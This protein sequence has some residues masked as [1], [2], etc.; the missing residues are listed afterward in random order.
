VLEACGV[1]DEGAAASLG[2]AEDAPGNEAAGA[3]AAVDANVA[4]ADAGAP[5]A[6]DAGAPAA[7]DAGATEEVLAASGD[8]RRAL[9]APA[10]ATR[11]MPD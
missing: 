9:V 5:A 10:R 2:A 11:C 4:E 7:L 8:A 1:V 3:A 6:L